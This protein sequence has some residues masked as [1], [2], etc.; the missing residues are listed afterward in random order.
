MELPQHHLGSNLFNQEGA[1]ESSTGLVETSLSKRWTWEFGNRST[2]LHIREE[3]VGEVVGIL[4]DRNHVLLKCAVLINQWEE[5]WTK[6]IKSTPSY[7]LNESWYKIFYRWYITP[8]IISKIEK[9]F[10]TMLEMPR[11]RRSVLLHVVDVYKPPKA[12]ERYT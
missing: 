2:G 7:N 10:S 9:L 5:L 1:G 6:S 3:M 4:V 12:L 8:S 11:N